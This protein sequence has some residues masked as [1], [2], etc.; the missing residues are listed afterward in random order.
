MIHALFFGFVFALG[1]ILPLGPQNMF[2]IQQGA[3]KHHLLKISIL[4]ATAALCDTLLI[5][6][7]VFGISV[8]VFKLAW[9]KYLMLVLGILFLAYLGWQSW[10]SQQH[11]AGKHKIV[12]L[13]KLVTFTL[14]VSL[15]NPAALIDTI[16]TIGSV[17]LTFTGHLRIDFTLGCI[18][19]SWLWFILLAVCGSQLQ[20][21]QWLYIRLPKIS[22]IV[23]WLAGG[24]LLYQ[25]FV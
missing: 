21:M 19:T 12:S 11:D 18:V 5:L 2:I 23:M 6:L 20:R 25:L 7:A 9:V 24:Y 16:V 13:K 3:N 22:A 8:A 10:R 1:L 17:S 15:L 4:V 14:A